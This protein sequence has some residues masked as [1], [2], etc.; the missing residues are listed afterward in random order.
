MNVER[1]RRTTTMLFIVGGLLVTLGL[2]FF[3]GPL[4]SGSPDGL[5]KVAIDEGFDGAAEDHTLGDSRFADYGVAGV[6]D[7][8]LATGIAGLVG[9]V[10]TF[11]AGL[12]L[13]GLVRVQRQ[14]R[15]HDRAPSPT[16][17]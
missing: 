1:G 12:L 2:A 8:A 17:A 11:G 4:A 10:V 13:F 7:D 6:E 14:R 16:A 5:E 9:V 15:Q 3:V